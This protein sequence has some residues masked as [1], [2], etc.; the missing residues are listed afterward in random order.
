MISLLQ[1][2]YSLSKSLILFFV[3]L[4]G[5]VIYHLIMRQRYTKKWFHPNFLANLLLRYL[6]Y[7]Q[8]TK[9]S[10]RI[11][12]LAD[13]DVDAFLFAQHL[14]ELLVDLVEVFMPGVDFEGW[15]SA[16][17]VFHPVFSQV[18]GTN[19]LFDI[20]RMI[21]RHCKIRVIFSRLF[22]FLFFSS[23]NVW[24]VKRIL[25]KT[26]IGKPSFGQNDV[27]GGEKSVLGNHFCWFLRI[28]KILPDMML[29]NV[30]QRIFVSV[31]RDWCSR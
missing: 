29:V 23:Q 20:V 9:D 6:C 24:P 28:Q 15:I 10:L 5:H 16:I 7:E 4:M 25:A 3:V 19:E 21:F 27:S 13:L 17:L 11:Q 22:F 31:Q 30:F 1:I 8:E 18:K 12:L 14:D 2:S 26:R